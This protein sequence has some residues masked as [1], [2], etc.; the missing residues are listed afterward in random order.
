MIRY[1]THSSFLEWTS[2]IMLNLKASQY[3]TIGLFVP[4][5]FRQAYLPRWFSYVVLALMIAFV[6]LTALLY[7]WKLA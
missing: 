3:P 5:S 6:P 4:I 1:E 2:A 7:M